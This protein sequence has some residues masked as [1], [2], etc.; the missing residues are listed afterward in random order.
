MDHGGPLQEASLP[1]PSRTEDLVVGVEG[2]RL[3]KSNAAQINRQL[4]RQGNSYKQNRG[5]GKE[6]PQRKMELNPCT[7]AKCLKMHKKCEDF[8]H[9]IRKSIQPA[10]PQQLY[11]TRLPIAPAKYKDLKKL[12]DQCVIPRRFKD[13]YLSLPYA[14]R[15]EDNLAETDEEDDVT[16]SDEED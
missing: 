15:V 8:D 10:N 13:E 12:C 3:K 16:P 11:E 1:E 4:K 5:R 2:K 7:P 9:E 6:I 14:G